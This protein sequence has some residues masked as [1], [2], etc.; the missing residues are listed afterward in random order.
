[1]KYLDRLSALAKS[2]T[3]VGEE[4]AKPAKA[5]F[6]A[7]AATPP[8]LFPNSS[9]TS[10]ATATTNTAERHC[11]FRLAYPDGNVTEVRTLPEATLEETRL[12]W[13]GAAVE[14]LPDRAPAVP[15]GRPLSD[16]LALLGRVAAAY[17]TPFGELAEMKRLALADPAAAWSGF[18]ATAKTEGIQ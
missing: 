4:P 8:P 17:R 15:D 7:S 3:R 11:R 9:A 13:P 10:A 6:A 1:M 5:P 18:L 2:G 14:A 16:L 12:L